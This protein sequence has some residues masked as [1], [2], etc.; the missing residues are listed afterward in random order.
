MRPTTESA[1]CPLPPLLLRLRAALTQWNILLNVGGNHRSTGKGSKFRWAADWDALCSAS[2]SDW[3]NTPRHTERTGPLRRWVR[4]CA[5]APRRLQMRDA[6]MKQRESEALLG[7]QVQ[8]KVSE[9]ERE[10]LSVTYQSISLSLSLP[11]P[12]CLPLHEA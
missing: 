2:P 7:Y 6:D 5:T 4:G 9:R 12:T 3:P 10:R 1:S 8:R 11:H